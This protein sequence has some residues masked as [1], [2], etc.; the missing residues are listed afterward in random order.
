MFDASLEPVAYH[1]IKGN[2]LFLM[3]YSNGYSQQT[4]LQFPYSE[5]IC[6]YFRIE[7]YFTILRQNGEISTKK[8]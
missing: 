6:F 8:V 3:C 1:E 4:L 2:G 5:F 7:V